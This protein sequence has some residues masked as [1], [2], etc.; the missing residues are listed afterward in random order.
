MMSMGRVP[1]LTSFILETLESLK[2]IG[3]DLIEFSNPFEA[4]IEKVKRISAKHAGYNFKTSQNKHNF[5]SLLYQLQKQ[6][7]VEKKEKDDRSFWMITKLGRERLR[8]IQEN[9]LPLNINYKIKKEKTSKLVIFD[10]PEK[11]KH[12]RNWLREQLVML[13][14]EMLQKSVWTG[15]NKI[16]QEFIRDLENFNLLDYVHILS[17][18]DKGTLN[19]QY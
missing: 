7:L 13:D 8:N 2:E 6:G 10:I 1:K 11:Y 14:F 9:S 19:D 17:I 16:P 18:K 3:V 12:K 15:K 5:R 4:Y